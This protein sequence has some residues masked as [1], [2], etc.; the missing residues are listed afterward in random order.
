MSARLRLTSA[1]FSTGR[2]LK[3]SV[4]PFKP[5]VP[6]AFQVSPDQ[7]PITSGPSMRAAAAGHQNEASVPFAANVAASWSGVPLAEAE[8]VSAPE[9]MPPSRKGL[10]RAASRVPPASA[11]RLRTRDASSSVGFQAGSRSAVPFTSIAVAPISALSTWRRTGCS[12]SLPRTSRAITGA[13]A[14]TRP[15]FVSK[16]RPSMRISPRPA[17]GAMGSK[18][19]SAVTPP[20]RRSER[21]SIP[22][23]LSR[24]SESTSGACAWMEISPGAGSNGSLASSGI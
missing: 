1:P 22:R 5:A 12:S 10:R 24:D 15:S 18:V 6:L 17:A 2:A 20:R 11:E 14:A 19:R 21:V 4:P 9:A 16:L 23:A 8:K 3:A 13:S 7:E